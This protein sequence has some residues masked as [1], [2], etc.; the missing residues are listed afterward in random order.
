M[1]HNDKFASDE[2]DY[3]LCCVELFGSGTLWLSKR[4]YYCVVGL[5]DYKQISYKYINS[6]KMQQALAAKCCNYWDLAIT[7][8]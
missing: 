1:T 8:H 5:V 6:N 3:L 7:I 4:W 2:P